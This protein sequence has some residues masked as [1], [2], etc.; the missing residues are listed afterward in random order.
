MEITGA[1][2]NYLNM[3]SLLS[4]LGVAGSSAIQLKQLLAWSLSVYV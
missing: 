3:S 1:Y 4:P 2:L